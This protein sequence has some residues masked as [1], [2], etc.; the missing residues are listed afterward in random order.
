MNPPNTTPPVGTEPEPTAQPS[1]QPKPYATVEEAE[2]FWQNRMSGKDRAAHAAEQALR[3]ENERL[4][5][6]VDTRASSA[7]QSGTGADDPTV[8]AL[9]EQNEQLQREATEARD[10]AALQ[11]RKSKYPN[12]VAQGLSDD[13]F[14]VTDDASL[15]KLNALADDSGST[16]AGGGFIA[17]T[18][19]ARGTQAQPKP[20]AQMSKEELEAQLQRTVDAGGHLRR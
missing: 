10:S 9:R 18:S 8:K 20:L 2:A 16:N 12:L 13:I 4:R 7:G 1:A 14:K 11:V 5:S 15:A 19:P 3:E 6:I 17:P